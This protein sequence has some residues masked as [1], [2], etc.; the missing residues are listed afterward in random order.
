MVLLMMP[1]GVQL[2]SAQDEMKLKSFILHHALR[3]LA[4]C[5]LQAHSKQAQ[6]EL[7][8]HRLQLELVCL[9]SSL[10]A[11]GQGFVF[12]VFRFYWC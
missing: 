3:I 6:G 2:S 11:V 10:A 8:S 9:S 7:A 4:M 12:W 5:F 1:A